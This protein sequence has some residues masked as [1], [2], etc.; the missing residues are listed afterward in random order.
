MPGSDIY[1]DKLLKL[2]DIIISHAPGGMQLLYQP[3]AD[4][5][6]YGRRLKSAST[7]SE[8]IAILEPIAYRGIFPTVIVFN[9]ILQRLG[10]FE[11]WPIAEKLYSYLYTQGLTDEITYS[12][13]I[14][15]ATFNHQTEFAKTVCQHACDK[16]QMNEIIL[17]NI[18]D[19]LVLDQKY[20]HEAKILYD[21]SNF[22][23]LKA[24][25]S[26]NTLIVDLHGLTYGVAYLAL[27]KFLYHIKSHTEIHVITGRGVHSRKPRVIYALQQAVVDV[28]KTLKSTTR[29]TISIDSH[30]PGLFKL[31]YHPFVFKTALNHNAKEFEPSSTKSPSLFTPTLPIENKS[32]DKST[33]TPTRT[34]TQTFRKKLK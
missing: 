31:D 25:I 2:I 29:T 30:N 27:T 7:I 11:S 8:F 9:Q 1:H 17:A 26:E 15:A 23:P 5:E 34:P 21:K 14:V 28:Y 19:A 6:D 33:Q 4:L 32:Q 24:K 10:Y 16:N 12:I 13:M 3:G 22:S 20:V 18:I